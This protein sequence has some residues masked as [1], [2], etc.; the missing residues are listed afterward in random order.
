MNVVKNVVNFASAIICRRAL[1]KIQIPFG[2]TLG[3]YRVLRRISKAET[4]DLKKLTISGIS[5]NSTGS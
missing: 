4:E 2:K 1:K 3:N 5:Q